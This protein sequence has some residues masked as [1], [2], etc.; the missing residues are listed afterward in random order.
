MSDL[1]SCGIE[2]LMHSIDRYDPTKGPTLEQYA[3][4]RIHGT[5]LDELRRQDWAPRS[6][7]RWERDI[8]E[9]EQRF[10][11]LYNRSPKREELADAMGVTVEELRKWQHDIAASNVT[12]LQSVIFSDDETPVEVIETIEGNDSSVD[13]E[14]ATVLQV[15]KERFR[16]VF[17]TLP[18]RDR[19][20]AILL[21]VHDLT[22]REVGDVLGVT[23][24]RIS[25]IHSALKKHIR[26][27]LEKSDDGALFNAL[28]A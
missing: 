3:W 4:T 12:S 24:S 1:V 19:Q 27:Q 11:V 9:A 18:E 10:V 17:Q 2:A 25:Q 15:A 13:P 28:V 21:Y 22:M 26:A 7:R 8:R 16:E 23:E 14:Q 6:V 5:I 20:V